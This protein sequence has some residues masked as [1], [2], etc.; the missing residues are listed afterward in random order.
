M[1]KSIVEELAGEGGADPAEVRRNRRKV[2]LACLGILLAAFLLTFFDQGV[3]GNEEYS[4]E[5][6]GHPGEEPPA[7]EIEFMI[8]YLESDH[9]PRLEDKYPGMTPELYY[10]M[11][12]RDFD[13]AQVMRKNY[14]REGYAP[15]RH[16]KIEKLLQDVQKQH[17]LTPDGKRK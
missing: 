1:G 7:D 9:G 14:G 12:K 2:I 11:K 15:K 4:G 3:S 17:N 5:I 13:L 6:T 8:Q 10:W 16:A